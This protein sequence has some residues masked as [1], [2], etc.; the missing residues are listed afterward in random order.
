VLFDCFKS[1]PI[2]RRAYIDTEN[3]KNLIIPDMH[4]R[5]DIQHIRNCFG[6]YEVYI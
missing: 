1:A 4:S 5:N 2:G 3:M 6:S